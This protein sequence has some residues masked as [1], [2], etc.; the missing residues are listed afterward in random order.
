MKSLRLILAASLLIPTAC[1][2]ADTPGLRVE[3]IEWRK[4]KFTL[5][6]VDLNKATLSL[7][8]SDE[9]G[10]P[11]KSFDR[12]EVFLK[13]QKQNLIW[14]MNAG[15]YHPD[16]S[17]VGL[18]VQDQKILNPLNTTEG[19]GNFFLKPNG[20][21]ALTN[22]GA[23]V[24]ETADF[25][26]NSPICQLA[27]QSGPLL[28]RHGNIHPAFQENSPNR[29]IRNAVGV[30]DAQTVIFVISDTPVTFHEC[31]TLFRDPLKCPNA[32]YL[33]GTVSSLYAPVKN[34]SDHAY[35]LGPILAVTTSPP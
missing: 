13:N 23:M 30:R 20:V 33:D 3:T 11:L 4:Q 5:T 6:T 12:L 28:L 2:H 32:L 21:F 27:T 22:Q 35:P 31:A 29:L 10:Q 7:F 18:L 15:M 19:A 17:P 9:S 14:A 26:K 16:F 24:W 1:V 25:L 34:R 8:H